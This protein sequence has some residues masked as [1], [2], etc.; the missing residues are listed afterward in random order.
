MIAPEMNKGIVEILR[1]AVLRK[2]SAHKWKIRN[3]K[4]IIRIRT[5]LI[6]IRERIKVSTPFLKKGLLITRPLGFDGM[7]ISL[8][9]FSHIIKL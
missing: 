4:E 2:K 3:L 7:A 1:K 5:L 8:N 9:V 6:I